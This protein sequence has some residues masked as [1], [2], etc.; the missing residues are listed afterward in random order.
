MLNAQLYDCRLDAIRNAIEYKKHRILPLSAPESA[1][2]SKQSLTNV[3]E[4]KDAGD[5]S[6]DAEGERLTRAKFNNMLD[7]DNNVGDDM[8]SDDNPNATSSIATAASTTLN[9]PPEHGSNNSNSIM[10][11]SNCSAS[12]NTNIGRNKDGRTTV[13]ESPGIIRTKV[14]SIESP[15]GIPPTNLTSPVQ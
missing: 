3:G 6:A 10:S 12:V 4:D 7:D 2:K 9:P 13:F 5:T 1:K 15:L 11:A 14:N 8:N